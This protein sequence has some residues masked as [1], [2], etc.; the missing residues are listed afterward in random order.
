MSL[1]EILRLRRKRPPTLDALEG[2]TTRDRHFD[3]NARLYL[4]ALLMQKS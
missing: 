4:F 2:P 3:R 1:L